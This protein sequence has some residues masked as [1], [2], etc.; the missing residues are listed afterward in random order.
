MALGSSIV[1]VIDTHCNRYLP[2]NWKNAR[3]TSKLLLV[4]QVIFA[5]EISTRTA[6]GSKY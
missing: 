5:C 3:V 2:I 6:Q 4:R 1:M